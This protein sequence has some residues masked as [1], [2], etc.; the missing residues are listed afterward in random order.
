MCHHFTYNNVLSALVLPVHLPP[1][2]V[3]C[4]LELLW[5][6]VC[7]CG[8]KAELQEVAGE[9][10]LHGCL[11]VIKHTCR[12][13]TPPERSASRVFVRIKRFGQS[14]RETGNGREGSNP[15]K[16]DLNERA[17]PGVFFA[18]KFYVSTHVSLVCWHQHGHPITREL[19]FI[20]SP[21]RHHVHQPLF[22]P[23]N[24]QVQITGASR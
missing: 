8:W 21:L 15:R 5:R 6:Y 4:K 13:V 1:S 18:S 24:S 17:T 16:L 19:F 3:F 23:T 22:H 11:S 10:F 7:V 2:F 9:L 12:D 20:C 14:R